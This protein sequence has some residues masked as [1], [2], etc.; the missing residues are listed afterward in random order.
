MPKK[1]P[2]LTVVP[3]QVDRSFQLLEH[4]DYEYIEFY[5]SI[6]D[7]VIAIRGAVT[8]ADL[9]L[10]FSA[11]QAAQGEAMARKFAV[12]AR[13][14]Q[15]AKRFMEFTKL[16]QS[17]LRSKSAAL[18]CLGLSGDRRGASKSKLT[19]FVVNSKSAERTGSGGSRWSDL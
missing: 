1:P 17:E 2:H 6:V 14:A 7:E 19:A 15:N 8:Q 16:A 18:S 10:I 11:T 13:E 9:T 4:F 5:E 3:D 12:E